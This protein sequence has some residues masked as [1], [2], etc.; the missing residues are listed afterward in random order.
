MDEIEKKIC[1]VIDKHRDELI[2]FGEDLW[3]HAELGFQEHRTAGKFAN[4]MKS[5]GLR[6]E[7]SLAVTGVK[8]YLKD[9]AD[10]PTVCLM[11]EFD[12]LPIP[13]HPH[14]NPETG[15]AHCCGHHAQATGVVGAAIALCDPEIAE[16]LD[17]NVV[18]FGVPAEEYVEI[19]K[20]N[21]MRQQG[22]IRYGC[23]KC[24]LLRI[25]AMDD[26]DIVVGHHASTSKQYLV[27]NRS[28]NGFV[29]KM[30]QFHGRAAH[31]AGE[32]ERGIDAM[33]AANI[34]MH[35]VDVQRESFRDGD[36][37]RVHACISKGGDA[38]N[39]IA[40]DVRLE[41]SIRGKTIPAYQDAARKVDR[42]MHAG[43]VATGCG[44]TIT[45]L[46]GNLPIVPV[47]DASVVEEA[48]QLICGD[49]PVTCTGPE[50]HST[51]SGDYG[52]VSCIMPLLQFNTGGFRGTLH[53][54][55]VELTDLDD[56]YIV[57][58]KVFA[59]IAYKLLK[60]GGN[61]AKAIIDSFEAVLTKEQYLKLMEGML[62]V[63]EMEMKLLPALE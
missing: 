1:A 20:R 21:K 10:G 27:A 35:A 26:L 61:R 30:V 11:G 2:A 9:S 13:T 22:L 12:G 5:L 50:F 53:S 45:N 49:T 34:A 17:G 28:C 60:N 48:L 37:V 7:E 43:A 57:P 33:N 54:P 51:S 62:S 56:A 6:T 59:L 8:S 46:P 32:P 52:D 19:E 14:A 15:A 31:A 41:Y 40:D 55:D 25:G 63:D 39:I 4:Q 42:A 47:K 16:A 58:A 38:P 18:F 23:G 44:L 29:T 36:T 24:E 3:L